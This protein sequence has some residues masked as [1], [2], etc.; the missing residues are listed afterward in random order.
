[1]RYIGTAQY[2]ILK[3]LLRCGS[4]HGVDIPARAKEFYNA[5]LLVSNVYTT[6][7]K[8][9]NKGLV[10]GVVEDPSPM[11]SRR[12]RRKIYLLTEAAEPL[13]IEEAM[14]RDREVLV[15][16]ERPPFPARPPYATE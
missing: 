2:L 15:R 16:R 9:L 14:R 1:M 5:D 4:V 13:V 12:E 11:A 3:V 10:E 8:L 7:K 6:L